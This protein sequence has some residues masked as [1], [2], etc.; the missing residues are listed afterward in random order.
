MMEAMMK[1]KMVILG[2]GA[3]LVSVL[4]AAWGAKRVVSADKKPPGDEGK[5]GPPVAAQMTEDPNTYAIPWL[6]VNGG[7]IDTAA[8]LSYRMGL[9]VGQAAA[10]EA[11]GPS[12]NMRVGFWVK[13]SVVP[14]FPG[15]FAGNTYWDAQHVGTCQ[16]QIEA[17]IGTMT[18]GKRFV[19]VTWMVLKEAN[20]PA[21]RDWPSQ[22][23]PLTQVNYNMYDWT[24]PDWACGGDSYGG[25]K[26]CEDLW[27]SGYT[28]LD[29]NSMGNAVASFDDRPEGGMDATIIARTS[30]MYP[31]GD[32]CS[33]GDWN[34]GPHGQISKSGLPNG[35]I[36]HL[37]AQ[38]SVCGPGDPPSIVYWP[39]TKLK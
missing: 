2:V 27:H 14:R 33:R 9:S 18:E 38:E 13:R 15:I 26:L 23:P 8:S 25:K 28:Y 17:D 34:I 4:I 21:F 36:Y 16:R 7:G 37:V 31:P 3:V 39:F 24:I 6:S 11:T 30:F 19:H 12:Y 35:D 32:V 20:I 29:V 5:N 10:G 1:N 22:S